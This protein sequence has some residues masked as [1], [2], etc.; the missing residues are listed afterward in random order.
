MCA[1][2]P[3]WVKSLEEALG[4]QGLSPAVTQQQQLAGRL[5]FARCS[6]FGRAGS[7]HLRSLHNQATQGSDKAR[8]PLR[9]SLSWWLPIPY[10]VHFWQRDPLEDGRT[11]SPAV[12]FTDATGHGKVG[13]AVH[14][15][16]GKLL[17]WSDAD[18]PEGFATLLLPRKSQVTP[19]EL[20]AVTW[21]TRLFE[22]MLR[23]RLVHIHVDNTAAECILEKKWPFPQILTPLWQDCGWRSSK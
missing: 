16:D 10:A 4:H 2:C 23:D 13:A 22:S 20:I 17:A 3:L 18:A 5:L 6:L 15:T 7:A 1:D 21:A 12:L 19:W 8:P 9:R 11:L 14:D